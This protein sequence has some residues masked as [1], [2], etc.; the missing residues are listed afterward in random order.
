MVSRFRSSHLRTIGRGSKLSSSNDKIIRSI[1]DVITAVG[2]L[3]SNIQDAPDL[4][5]ARKHVAIESVTAVAENLEKINRT[6]FLDDELEGQDLALEQEVKQAISEIS[7]LTLPIPGDFELVDNKH[8]SETPIPSSEHYQPLSP[9]PEFVPG[10]SANLE[11]LSDQPDNEDISAHIQTSDE[12]LSNLV[13]EDRVHDE[14]DVTLPVSAEISNNLM[15]IKGIDEEVVELLNRHGI[16]CFHDIA[17]FQEADVMRI[18]EQLGDPGRVARECWVEQATLLEQDQPTFYAL[19]FTGSQPFNRSELYESDLFVSSVAQ[20][21]TYGDYHDS[22]NDNVASLGDMQTTIDDHENVHQN[23][24]EQQDT[25]FSQEIGF[26]QNADLSPADN[27]EGLGQ[28]E[29]KDLSARSLSSMLSDLGNDIED[30]TID[31]QESAQAEDEFQREEISEKDLKQEGEDQP[32]LTGELV[33]AQMD[34]AM[35]HEEVSISADYVSP[36]VDETEDQAT[37]SDNFADEPDAGFD[38]A[39]TVYSD[40]ADIYVNP[41][42]TGVMSSEI[43]ETEIIPDQAALDMRFD[44]DI[45]VAPHPLQAL[46]D[47]V[48]EEIRNQDE[49]DDLQEVGDEQ[50]APP[51]LPS[52]DVPDLNN[53]PMA[54]M[55]RSLNSGQGFPA[56]RPVDPSD[57]REAAMMPPPLPQGQGHPPQAHIHH[58]TPPPTP[59]PNHMVGG[60]GRFHHEPVD[61]HLPMGDIARPLTSIPRGEAEAGH[62]QQTHLSQQP[63]RPPLPHGINERVVNNEQWVKRQPDGPPILPESGNGNG[64]GIEQRE[65]RD[66]V[67]LRG[68]P[69]EKPVSK[70]FRAKAKKFAET[71][72]RSFKDQN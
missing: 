23:G 50:V 10:Y 55:Q 16:E 40:V 14:S 36:I 35:W 5:K 52:R 62:I 56:F 19:S 7:D 43:D 18:S 47:S 67:Y 68:K 58:S 33:Q 21:F 59:P 54:D 11:A 32:E 71:L 44:P 39:E 20:S 25:S 9:L 63:P 45:S 13:S 38:S 30:D 37:E 26:I 31:I 3:V 34:G 12:A 70:G 2:Q 1:D 64:K 22:L 65:W 53:V 27:E 66:H 49:R 28:G 17:R 72:Q 48:V 15:L 69:P 42:E 51:P 4:D 29:D 6:L 41:D 61:A 46:K 24:F 8:P 57:F 60:Q